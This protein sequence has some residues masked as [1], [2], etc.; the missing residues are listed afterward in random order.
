MMTSSN[1]N[2][3]RIAGHLC[4]EFTVPGE[5]PA[6][7]SVTRSFDIFFHLRLNKRLSKQLWD[8]WFQTPSSSWRQC[9]VN[10]SSR[11]YGDSPL[12][13]KTVR[14]P[15]YIYDRNPYIGEDVFTHV[16]LSTGPK[17]LHLTCHHCP[18]TQPQRN[19]THPQHGWYKSKPMEATNIGGCVRT[20]LNVFLLSLMFC[21]LMMVISLFR[22]TVKTS[23][24]AMSLICP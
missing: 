2:I 4:E 15:F 8:W 11:K 13:D 3:F 1:G 23:V 18:Q 19:H 16:F 14:R 9:N 21:I 22:W 24:R 7:R 20:L 12:K 17:S 6:Q 5:F 10:V